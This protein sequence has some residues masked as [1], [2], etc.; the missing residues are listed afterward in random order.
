MATYLRLRS[1]RKRKRSEMMASAQVKKITV[2][3]E[4]RRKIA[5]MDLKLPAV[6]PG[7]R[8]K[9]LENAQLQKEN[10]EKGK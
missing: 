5:L 7:L 8:T 10:P 3:E 1:G 2:S 6:F 9:F 4:G